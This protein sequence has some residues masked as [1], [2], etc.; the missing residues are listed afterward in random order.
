MGQGWE[1]SVFSNGF[2]EGFRLLWVFGGFLYSHTENGSSRLFGQDRDNMACYL[3]E[4]NSDFRF[5][6]L[7]SVNH[8]STKHNCLHASYKNTRCLVLASV[9][10]QF[11]LAR[12]VES[13]SVCALGPY[14][15]GARFGEECLFL[16]N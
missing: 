12:N 7:V 16:R 11:T 9:S 14:G 4:T 2:G 5:L 1:C 8:P 6:S 3:T 10:V 13:A 15:A